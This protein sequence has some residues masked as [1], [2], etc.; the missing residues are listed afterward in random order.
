MEDWAKIG[1]RKDVTIKID[2]SRESW[3]EIRKNSIGG[4]DA[5][6]IVGLN[7][8]KSNQQLWD[9]KAGNVIPEDI[10]EQPY[11]KYGNDAEPL[12]RELFALDYPNYKVMYVPYNS[13][14]NKRYP[15]AHY[16]AD[17]WLYDKE[18]DKYGFLEI[19]TTNILQSRQREV[20]DNRIP[21]NYFVQ[22]VHGLM[23]TDFDFVVLKAQLKSEFNGVIYLQTKHYYIDRSDVE[24][25]ITYLAEREENF[26]N[27]IR[28]GARPSMIL[29]EL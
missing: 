26:W 17:G 13:F 23:V 25:D 11:V 27:S 10:S 19:K 29:P 15:F 24:Q 6:C 9:E 21:D 28:Q 7:P 4:S 12:L 3:L 5:S 2:E 16:S 20:W 22:I 8:Y 1:N 14:H 18:N